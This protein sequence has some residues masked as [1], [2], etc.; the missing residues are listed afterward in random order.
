MKRTNWIDINY[1]HYYPDGLSGGILY[2][3]FMPPGRKVNRNIQGRCLGSK[4]SSLFY[5]PTYFDKIRRNLLLYAEFREN[6]HRKIQ[7]INM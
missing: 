7:K 6:I 5:V 2:G 4:A 1:W 3:L